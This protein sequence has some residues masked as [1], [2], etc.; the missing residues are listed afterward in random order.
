MNNLKVGTRLSLGFGC[1]CLLLL[2]TIGLGI[3]KVAALNE[4]TNYIVDNKMPKMEMAHTLLENVD[5]IAIALRNM[6]L[7]PNEDDRKGQLET[8]MAARRK[9]DDIMARMD[10]VHVTVEGRALLARVQDARARYMKGQNELIALI[11]AGREDESKQY[12][13]KELRPVL[14][15]YKEVLAILI[16]HEADGIAITA[17][18]AQQTYTDSRNQLIGLGVLALALAGVTGTLITRRLLKQLGGEPD[19]AA[20]IAGAIAAGNL[21]VHVALAKN[22]SGSLMFAMEAMRAQLAGV[23]RDVRAGTDLIATASGEIA[24]GNQELSARTEQQAGALEE[25]ASSLEELTS[26]VRQNADNA[27]Q[28][29]VLAESAS[30]VAAQGGAVVA[31]VVTTMESIA[32]SGKNIVDIIGVI[33][34]IAFQTNILALNAAVEAARAGEQGR[35]FAV[36]ASEVRTLAQ[37]SAEAAKEVK[38]LIDRS[39]QETDAGSRLV[40]EAGQ[41]MSAI[42]DSVQRVTDIMGEISAASAEQ[43][44]GIEQINM[45]VVQM[46]QVTQQNA[47]L[48][49]EAAAASASMQD[50]AASLSQAVG[51][52]T[53]DAAMAPTD[54]RIRHTGAR[55]PAQRL[56]A[57]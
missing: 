31:Q 42:I 16:K 49:E 57:A 43:S 20:E 22:D 54:S 45:A 15:A 47:A 2:I 53:L 24:A 23:V 9:V 13:V 27:R 17:K 39:V 12:L 26:T 56:L 36:V 29:N 5:A 41:T 14:L 52:F 8:I 21:G 3:S 48:V 37:R 46:D 6:M 35:G 51:V 50:Q 10:K 1:V 4:G 33:N 40:N 55:A 44:A 34:G 38:N 25:T 30:N 7:N 19:Y 32:A 11:Q 18:A 28:A